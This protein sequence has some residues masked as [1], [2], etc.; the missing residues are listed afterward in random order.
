MPTKSYLE[1][2]AQPAQS[3]VKG[4]D[5]DI[6]HGENLLMMG[7]SLVMMAP[8][9]APVMPPKLLLPLMALVFVWSVCAAR[10]N[11]QN[12]QRKLQAAQ[13]ACRHQDIIRLRP[14]L[15]VF[16]VY[17]KHSLAVGFN[18][19]KN[20][21]RTL[22][23]LLGGLL[24]NPLWMPIFYLLGLQFAEDKQLHQLNKAVL[25]VEQHVDVDAERQSQIP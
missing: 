11:F 25:V 21:L 3:I 22:K 13:P 18:P 4:I 15:Q 23:S 6:E 1:F 20:P 16:E 24:I 8:L 7:Y 5:R 9:L 2:A 17:P 12:I 19:L 10:F 14:I